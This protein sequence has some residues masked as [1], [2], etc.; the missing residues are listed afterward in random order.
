MAIV[1]PDHTHIDT[2][3]LGKTSMDKKSAGR[4]G[5]YVHSTQSSREAK[6]QA[7]DSFKTRNPAAANLLPKFNEFDNY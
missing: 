2:Y 4:R 5:R 7:S 6:S 1:S 3:T